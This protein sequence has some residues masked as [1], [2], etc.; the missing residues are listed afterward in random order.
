MDQMNKIVEV[1]GMPPKSM[2]DSAHKTKKYFDK[3]PDGSY[4]LRKSKEGKKYKAPGNRRLHDI[5]G[6]F[7]LMQ[8]ISFSSFSLNQLHKND[9]KWQDSFSHRL[10]AMNISIFFFLKFYYLLN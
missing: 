10:D 5:I 1:L 7:I 6:E 3:L 2:L 4:M 9:F 8:F